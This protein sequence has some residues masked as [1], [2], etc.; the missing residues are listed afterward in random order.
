MH[1][2]VTTWHYE[3]DVLA[4][5]NKTGLTQNYKVII[6]YPSGSLAC[7]TNQMDY[8]GNWTG[9]VKQ[10]TATP[11]QE[12][13]LPLAAGW[14]AYP[15][16]TANFVKTQEGL[17]VVTADVYKGPGTT[18][19]PGYHRISQL[20]PGYWPRKDVAWGNTENAPRIKVFHDGIVE[21]YTAVATNYFVCGIAYPAS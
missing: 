7:Y 19:D 3:I 21:I 15:E 14:S 2:P 20:P 8:T 17:V 5:E 13:D 12:I 4:G 6:V 11:L 10:A 16:H 1:L 18:I 9:W